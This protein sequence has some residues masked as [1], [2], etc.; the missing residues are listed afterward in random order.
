MAAMPL[1]EMI[2]IILKMSKSCQ[3]QEGKGCNNMKKEY[4]LLVNEDS[5]WLVVPDNTPIE[6]VWDID[7]YIATEELKDIIR[8]KNVV[9]SLIEQLECNLVVETNME[10]YPFK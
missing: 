6:E 8:E 4:P 1:Q 9:K 7:T 5:V 3:N 2:L 10:Y